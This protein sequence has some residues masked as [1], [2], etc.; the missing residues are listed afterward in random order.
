MN[1]STASN[2]T[3]LAALLL[4][5]LAAACGGDDDT[6]GGRPGGGRFGGR[7]AQPVETAVVEVGDI[8]RTIVLPGT[9]EPIR[10]VGINAQ[11]AGAILDIPVEEGDRVEKGQI[12]A[13]LDDR[14]LQAQ[15][16]SAEAAYEVTEAALA[17]S[18]QLL[19]RQIITRPEFEADRTAYEAARSQLDQLRTR[20]EFT[21]VRSP[22]SGVISVQEVQAGDVVGPQGRLLEVAEV[23]T[24][25][26]RVSVSELDV[27]QIQAGDPVEV[28]LDALPGEVL[29]ASV[30][31]VFPTA[32]PATRLIPVEVAL[33][34]ADGTR[35]RPGFLARVAF[36]LDP[37]PNARLVPAGAIVSRGGGEG[38]YVVADSTVVLRSVTPGLTAGGKI[39]IV[40]GLEVGE[41]V[42]TLGSNLLRD[43]SKIRDVSAPPVE[44]TANEPG[45]E[46][47]ATAPSLDAQGD[48]GTNATAE[49]AASS[50]PGRSRS[51][52]DR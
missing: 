42:V 43:G 37:K 27:V 15:L 3:R 44:R 40:D 25:V 18:T 6:G 48:V 41:R 12:V 46:R 20:V 14:E 26:V 17:R 35:V 49:A 52:V 38:V 28:E 32:D 9:V 50:A 24:L 2:G 19:E 4:L 29:D 10:S 8:A 51:G 39:E 21:E 5:P 47:D 1:R 23:D 30:R 22:I 13:R 11:V 34:S 36:Q 45:G 33:S 31:R 7:P 16:R